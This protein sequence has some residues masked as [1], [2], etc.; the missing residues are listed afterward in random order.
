MQFSLERAAYA[1][2][3]GTGGF[4]GLIPERAVWLIAFED[5]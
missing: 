1:D 5:L 2:D 3:P 4:V